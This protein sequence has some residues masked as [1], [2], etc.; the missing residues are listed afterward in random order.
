MASNQSSIVVDSVNG[1]N[2]KGPLISNTP[3]QTSEYG[4]MS[5]KQINRNQASSD[6]H[7]NDYE[8]S[9]NQRRKQGQNTNGLEVKNVPL[10][11]NSRTNIIPSDYLLNNI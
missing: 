8:V 3:F 11:V 1:K 7:K 9:S 6:S 2:S 10:I 4:I 5:S